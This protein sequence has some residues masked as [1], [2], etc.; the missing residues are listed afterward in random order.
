MFV[1]LCRGITAKKVL[2]V[3]QDGACTVDQVTAC[4][5]AG[6][7]CGSCKTTI[8]RMIREE[9]VAESNREALSCAEA[10]PAVDAA[11]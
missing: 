10:A 6:G 11:A 5:G 3:I 7:D 9:R 8:A 4:C 1:C 2:N